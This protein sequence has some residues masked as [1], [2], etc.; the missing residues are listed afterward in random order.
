MKKFFLSSFVIAALVVATA[1]TSCNKN[2]GEEPVE[3]PGNVDVALYGTWNRTVTLTFERQPHWFYCNNCIANLFQGV[4]LNPCNDC[5]WINETKIENV[6]WVHEM[7]FND[8]SNFSMFSNELE[9]VKGAYSTD[10]GKITINPTNIKGLD[11]NFEKE[12]YTKNEMVETFQQLILE[13]MIDR[14]D[15]DIDR[16]INELFT[17]STFSYSVKGD[18]LTFT[19]EDEKQEFIRKNCNRNSEKVK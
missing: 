14:T 13:G 17:S 6:E 2:P 18:Q 10:N 15:E 12:W 7:V 11:S 5:I 3:E 8:N 16:K 19:N 9:Y 1:F 4:G